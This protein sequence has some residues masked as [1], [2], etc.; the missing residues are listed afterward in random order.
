MSRK[1]NKK[2]KKKKTCNCIIPNIYTIISNCSSCSIRFKEISTRSFLNY[3]LDCFFKPD[4][5][6]FKLFLDDN[7][8]LSGKIITEFNF[9]D[10]SIFIPIETK[11]HNNII[12]LCL[13]YIRN[14]IEYYDILNLLTNNLTIKLSESEINTINDNIKNINMENIQIGCKHR[15]NETIYNST[16]KHDKLLVYS[17]TGNIKELKLLLK[18]YP[19][20]PKKKID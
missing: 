3:I 4:I 17:A 18:R 16:N 2:N 7:I 1:K 8:N 19:K 6:I 14:I 10:H 15:L 13:S 11:I 20:E 9:T 5:K 12:E